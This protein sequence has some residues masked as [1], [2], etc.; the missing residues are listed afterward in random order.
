MKLLHSCQTLLISYVKQDTTV[1]VP[2][3]ICLLTVEDICYLRQSNTG[4]IRQTKLV[5]SGLVDLFQMTRPSASKM[6]LKKSKRGCK[7][8][9]KFP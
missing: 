6:F 3:K 7:A 2:S 8:E 4:Q 1:T 5:K 9:N